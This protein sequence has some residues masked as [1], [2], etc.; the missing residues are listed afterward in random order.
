MP[1]VVMVAGDFGRFHAGH[2]DHLLRAAQ[3]GDFLLVI[4]HKD[5]SIR[6]R[7]GY[8]PEP[9]AVRMKKI[10]DLLT[11]HKI[12]YTIALSVDD[13]GTVVNT[14]ELY[15]PAIFAK[16]GDRTPDNMPQREVEVCAKLGIEVRYGIGEL[17][18]QSRTIARGGG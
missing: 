16:G 7:K 10:G 5:E 12:C 11:Q 2:A 1:K 15:Q 3:L 17:L 14:L 8:E 18:D 6:S 13:D 4:T 9:L